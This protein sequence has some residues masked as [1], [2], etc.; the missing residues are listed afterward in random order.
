MPAV[1]E[2]LALVVDLEARLDQLA[3]LAQSRLEVVRARSE[4]TADLVR[5]WG[6]A[7]KG[8]LLE[9]DQLVAEISAL[10]VRQAHLEDDKRLLEEELAEL[11]RRH[12]SPRQLTPADV[13]GEDL[14]A[15]AA[16]VERAEKRRERIGPVNPLAAQECAEAE[17]RARFLAEQRRDL[18]DSLAELKRV[19][20]E[21]DQHIERSFAEFFARTQEHFASVIAAVFPGAK[22]TL[23]LVAEEDSEGEKAASPGIGLEIKLPNKGP[24]SI[25]LLSGGEKAM[26]AIAFLFALF[27]AR[28]CPFYILDEVEASLDDVNIRRF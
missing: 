26:A 1:S 8:L 2:L 19:I 28:P 22:G 3:Q 25:S 13:E 17:E 18:E 9:R 5:D 6:G 7:E 14:A 15:L 27:L 21:L 4:E 24:R 12:L 20:E 16:A 11:R 23:R 10:Q